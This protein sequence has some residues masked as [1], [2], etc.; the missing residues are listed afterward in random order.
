MIQLFFQHFIKEGILKKLSRKEMQAR[1][2]YLVSYMYVCEY[3]TRNKITPMK[4]L[5]P[6]GDSVGN[7]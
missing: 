2:F 7:D 5:I 4:Q 1:M 6:K 3:S